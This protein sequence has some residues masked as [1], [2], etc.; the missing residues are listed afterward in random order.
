MKHVHKHALKDYLCAL[1]VYLC[2]LIS[3]PVCAC[4]HTEFRENIH[5]DMQVGPR[6]LYMDP[7]NAISRSIIAV[8]TSVSLPT[9]NTGSLYDYLTSV[10]SYT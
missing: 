3:Q 10:N 4:R 1:Q 5:R 7:K 2:A 8:M 6:T 9:N